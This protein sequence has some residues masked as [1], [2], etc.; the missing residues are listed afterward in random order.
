MFYNG[1]NILV[2]EA[3]KINE[4]KKDDVTRRLTPLLLLVLYILPDSVFISSVLKLF[5]FGVA[6]KVKLSTYILTH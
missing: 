4:D 1:L 5:D 6:L 2:T 3:M